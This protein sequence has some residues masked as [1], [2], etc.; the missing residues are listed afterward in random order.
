MITGTIL[1]DLAHL[2]YVPKDQALSLSLQDRQTKMAIKLYRDMMGVSSR[3]PV[4]EL[5]AIPRCACPDFGPDAGETGDVG[6]V[7]SANTG[8][9]SWPV[10]C[11]PDWPNN[12][13]MTYQVD[14]SNMPAFLQPVFE[15]AWSLCAQAAADI[16]MALVR[17]DNN[18]RAN[19]L[20]TFTTSRTWIGLAIVPSSPR[21]SDRIWAK[22]AISYKPADLVNQWARLLA[23]EIG[24]NWGRGHSNGGIMNPSII[25]GVFRP[26]AWRHDVLFDWMK[27]RF[28]GNPITPTW[29][30]YPGAEN[31]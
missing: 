26:D 14:K 15:D 19:S 31:G 28:G 27:A 18:N 2:G 9:G 25:G 12:H 16:G 1:G 20:I 10:G 24:H 23:H 7:A 22:F 8:S 6:A 29:G 17:E 13:A 3:V 30:I 11:H 4:D 5:F 21:C